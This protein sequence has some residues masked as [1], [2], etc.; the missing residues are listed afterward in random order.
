[1]NTHPYLRAYMAGI[2]VPTM[3]LL[4]IVA[5]YAVVRF[6]FDVSIPVERAIAFPMA[7]VPN[8]WGL[9]NMSTCDTL[10]PLGF[11]RDARAMLPV[12]LVPLGI[13]SRIDGASGDLRFRALHR[14]V[15]RGAVAADY[16]G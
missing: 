5:G 16:L 1:M 13:A 6:A 15:I 10:A 2:T 11:A 8:L 9:W 12:F 3:F 4:V 7:V 14:R